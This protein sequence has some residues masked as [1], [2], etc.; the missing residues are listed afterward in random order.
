MEAAF[1]M[2]SGDRFSP[3]SLAA[4]L[5][6]HDAPVVGWTHPAPR[7]DLPAKL[8]RM[9][10]IGSPDPGVMVCGKPDN[11]DWLFAQ[12]KGVSG[13][14]LNWMDKCSRRRKERDRPSRAGRRHG[15]TVSPFAS[16]RFRI[17]GHATRSL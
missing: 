14:T 3:Q 11:N 9:R 10:R 13:A 6:S 1:K 7:H 2:T 5:C 8:P 12:V 15:R 17:W 16:Q 4:Q